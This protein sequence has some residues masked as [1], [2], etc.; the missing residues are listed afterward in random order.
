MGK[1]S[2]AIRRFMYGRYGNDRLNMF[3]LITGVILCLISM[4]VRNLTVNVILTVISYA[5][6][7][8]AIFRSMSRNKYLRYQENRKFLSFRNRFKDRFSN[9][10]CIMRYLIGSNFSFACYWCLE[11]H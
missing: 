5:L 4:F 8:W 10:S 9:G 2:Q 6:M 7:I 3:L 1:F 11:L